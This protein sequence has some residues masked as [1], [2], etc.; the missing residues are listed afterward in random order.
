MD[1]G[2]AYQSETTAL[3]IA[4]HGSRKMETSSEIFALA[5]II[6]KK[7]GDDFARICVGF[8][9]FGE[10]RIQDVMEDCVVN[11]IKT[12]II[13]PFFAAAGTHVL[14]DLPRL[15]DQFRTHHPRIQCLLTSHL[16]KYEDLADVILSQVKKDMDVFMGCKIKS[17]ERN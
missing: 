3:L 2:E 7:S 16:G 11:G 4:A 8:L 14:A 17:F 15:V 10:P 9:E 13:F 1:K 6:E 5:D 12:I